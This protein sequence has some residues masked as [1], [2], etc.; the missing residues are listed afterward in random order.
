MTKTQTELGEEARNFG[1]SPGRGGRFV[2]TS[3]GRGALRNIEIGN[4]PIAAKRSAHNTVP[5]DSPAALGQ[6]DS[7]EHKGDQYGFKNQ[8]IIYGKNVHS[9]QTEA[10]LQEL[11]VIDSGTQYY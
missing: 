9:I 6:T 10:H 5:G 7:P 3:G 11:L 1:T 4:F 8:F 2:S